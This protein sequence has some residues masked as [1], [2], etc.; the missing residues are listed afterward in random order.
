MKFYLA[1]YDCID[2]TRLFLCPDPFKIFL[3]ISWLPHELNAL[4]DEIKK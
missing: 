4:V 3:K 2:H 1:V